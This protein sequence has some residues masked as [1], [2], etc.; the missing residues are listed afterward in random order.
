MDDSLL[1][2]V[3][4]L[5]EAASY[6]HVTVEELRAEL[7]DGRIPGLKVADHW[8]IKREALDRLLDPTVSTDKEAKAVTVLSDVNSE[9]PESAQTETVLIPIE[10]EVSEDIVTA[11]ADHAEDEVS[12]SLQQPPSSVTLTPPPGRLWAHVFAYNPKRGIGYARLQDNRVVWLDSKHLVQRDATLFP[13]DTVE[14]ELEHS[15]NGPEGRVIQVI[16][17]GDGRL[18]SCP[19]GRRA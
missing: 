6:L 2:S 13:G 16:P 11:R 14:F 19:S 15:Q 9:K 8:R 10:P 17:K 12:T 5:E 1:S 18:V 4:T 3:L 7:E